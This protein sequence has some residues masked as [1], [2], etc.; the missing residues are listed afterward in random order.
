MNLIIVAPH[1]PPSA[2]PPAQRVRLLVRNL[3]SLGVQTKVITVPSKYRE[4]KEDS[5]MLELAGEDFELIQT[6]ALHY[7]WTRKLGIGDLG[8]RMLPFLF[9]TLLKHCQKKSTD[10]VLYPVPPWY[11]LLIAPI[12]KKL[13]KVPYAIDFIDPWVAL[14][15]DEVAKGIKQR[16]SNWIANKSE[17][18]VCQ[19]ADIIYAVSAG[20]NEGLTQR[21]P[22]LKKIPQ[23]AVPYGAEEKDFKTIDVKE[24]NR[25][26]LLIRYIGAVWEDAYPVVDSLLHAFSKVKSSYKAEF[27]GTSYAGEELAEPQLTETINKYELGSRIEEDPYR[28]PYKE[29]V[30]L[31]MEAD[32]LLLFGGMKSYYAASKLFGLIISKKPFFAFLHKDSFPAKFLKEVNYPFLVQYSNKNNELPKFQIEELISVIKQLITSV[33]RN[34]IFEFPKNMI[35]KHTA[36][37]MTNSFIEPMQEFIR[38]NN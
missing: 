14:D 36:L 11:I 2:L 34:E 7:K 33:N 37:G 4:E 28:K 24:N 29:A 8:L 5:W 31:Q 15:K 22:I 30:K 23:Y 1:F 20:I 25:N 6:E 35:E 21:H 13:T 12:I 18:F 38:S 3:D 32:L 27:I 26:D 19:N 10:F 17:A 16:L 9:F